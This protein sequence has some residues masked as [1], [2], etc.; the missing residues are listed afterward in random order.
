MERKGCCCQG[1]RG[2]QADSA[3]RVTL[4]CQTNLVL[5]VRSDILPGGEMERQRSVA[6]GK[7][8]CSRLLPMS[9]P[10]G[11]SRPIAVSCPCEASRAIAG[12]C[13][14]KPRDILLV[15]LGAPDL[16][17]VSTVCSRRNEAIA[18]RRC[19]RIAAVEWSGLQSWR[20]RPGRGRN[21][22]DTCHE[23]FGEASAL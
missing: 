2:Q 3:R 5:S 1:N 17:P 20:V 8:P 9:W 11:A 7:W 15:S 16:R 18:L 22:A 19:L 13:R 12:S 6:S 10:G 4:R 23:R 14:A 21:S